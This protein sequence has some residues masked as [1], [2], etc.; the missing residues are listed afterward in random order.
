MNSD[1]GRLSSTFHMVVVSFW[2]RLLPLAVLATS[3]IWVTQGL[4]GLTFSLLRRTEDSPWSQSVFWPPGSSSVGATRE[5]PGSFGESNLQCLHTTK[6]WHLLFL[7]KRAAIPKTIVSDKLAFG[8]SC[9]PQWGSK[10][11]QKS[12]IASSEKFPVNRRLLFL[13]CFYVHSKVKVTKLAKT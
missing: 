5:E 13:G 7:K 12:N 2:K 11:D 1:F 10:I 3:P 4:F 9:L 8:S 6:A